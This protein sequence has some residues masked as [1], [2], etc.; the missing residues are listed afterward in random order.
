[1]AAAS[2]G[3]VA[4]GSP[5]KAFG[6]VKPEQ[7][8][9]RANVIPELTSYLQ[10]QI[11]AQ[12]IPGAR[13]AATRH[14]K[15]FLEIC[16]GVYCDRTGRGKELTMD[17]VQ[18]LF[19]VSKMVSATAVVMVWQEGRLDIDAPAARYVPEFANSG[20]EKITIRQLLKAAVAKVCAMPLQWEPGSK[21]QYHGATGMLISAEAVRR[22]KSHS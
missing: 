1:M 17:V 4:G 20:K 8:R 18:P 7:V 5:S 10:A 11:D 22:G 12:V 21:T 16:L 19:S 14:G 15:A 6:A 3:R 13:V 2:A 9:V